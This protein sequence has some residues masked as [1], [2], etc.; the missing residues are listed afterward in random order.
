MSRVGNK[1]PKMAYLVN[2]I[3]AISVGEIVKEET[4]AA[5][6]SI[7]LHKIFHMGNSFVDK[8]RK[9]GTDV[10]KD[11]FTPDFPQEPNSCS[12]GRNGM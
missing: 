9:I 6:R 2:T 12:N 3:L 10:V 11:G 1:E 8:K 5:K 7:F 4:T